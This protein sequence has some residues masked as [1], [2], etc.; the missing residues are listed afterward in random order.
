MC[1]HQKSKKYISTQSDRNVLFIVYNYL[2]FFSSKF[3]K[4]MSY[5]TGLSIS[6]GYIAVEIIKLISDYVCFENYV[7]ISGLQFHKYNVKTTLY[8]CA[9]GIDG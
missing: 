1:P 5:K 7:D 8:K 2:T 6:H 9:W 4:K 3:N